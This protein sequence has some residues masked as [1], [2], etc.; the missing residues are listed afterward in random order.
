MAGEL[1]AIL[2]RCVILTCLAAVG[3][4]TPGDKAAVQFTLRERLLPLLEAAQTLRDMASVGMYVQ[5][6]GE[7]Y[8]AAKQKALEG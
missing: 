7:A 6:H 8:D 2:E 3:K 4:V 1:E 5:A